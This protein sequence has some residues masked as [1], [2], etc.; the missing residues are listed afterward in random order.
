MIAPIVLIHINK[1]KKC[2]YVHKIGQQK[3]GSRIVV[4]WHMGIF[5]HRFFV[6]STTSPTIFGYY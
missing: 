2:I 3:S 1:Q 4:L 6:K 5:S